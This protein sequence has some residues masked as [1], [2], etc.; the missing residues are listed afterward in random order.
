MNDDDKYI[1]GVSDIKTEDKKIK[2]NS[3]FIPRILQLFLRYYH[4]YNF[5]LHYR[6]QIDRHK[7]S[8]FITPV[9]DSHY[10]YF[11]IHLNANF[12]FF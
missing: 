2:T 7:T 12:H 1:A 3:I 10:I 11:L 4:Y 9:E 6:M 8:I 5:F